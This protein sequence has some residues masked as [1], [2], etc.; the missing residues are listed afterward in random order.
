MPDDTSTCSTV[1]FVTWLYEV[2]R[3]WRTPSIMLFMPWMYASP[4]SPP[5]V[6]VGSAPSSAMPPPLTKSLHSPGLQKPKDRKSV[7]WG[8][9]V[10]VRVD[11]GGR[12]IIKKK[13]I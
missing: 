1:F 6:L 8:K 13:N 5:L 11:H 2:P 7:V 9:S 10:S 4:V 12:R 3:I